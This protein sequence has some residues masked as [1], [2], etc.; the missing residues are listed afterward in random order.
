MALSAYAERRGVT[1][2]AVRKAIAERR[3]TESVVLVRG[4]HKIADAE[5]AD[6]E[7]D[8]RT[9]P[10]RVD[11]VT[12]AAEARTRSGADVAADVDRTLAADLEVDAGPRL[13]GSTLHSLSESRFQPPDSGIPY[14]EA[15]RRREVEAAKREAIK[16][17]GD[18]LDLAK[19][20]GELIDVDQARADV[21]KIFAVVRTKM[22]GVAARVKQRLPHIAHEDVREI[23]GLVREA[24]EALA[25]GAGDDAEESAE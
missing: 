6:A 25:N 10:P 22:L 16:R 19:R 21:E 5:L 2:V 24:L 17:K 8:E 11:W 15:R 20:R 1:T 9:R 3:L 7:W 4:K 12:P 13:D 23:D 14:H 18:E